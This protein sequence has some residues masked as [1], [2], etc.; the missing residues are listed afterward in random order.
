M[1]R[2]FARRAVIHARKSAEEPERWLAETIALAKP[3]CKCRACRM[4][5]RL[6]A[7]LEASR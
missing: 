2:A 7:E 4:L 1:L 6:K 5:L 3:G